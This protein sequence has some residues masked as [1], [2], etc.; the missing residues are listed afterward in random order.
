MGSGGSRELPAEVVWQM[1][2]VVKYQGQQVSTSH[3]EG[4]DLSMRF[5]FGAF[6]PGPAYELMRPVFHLF[7]AAHSED[8]RS[9]DE[10]KLTEYYR[11][12]DALGLT[13]ESDDGRLFKTG[14]IHIV[15]LGELGRHLEVQ[16]PDD[17]FWDVTP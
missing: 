6:T 3:L 4:R 12:R 17:V 16:V 15:D 10:S 8:W 14:V 13:L 11:A 2:Y 7:V 9:M 5:A 1:L